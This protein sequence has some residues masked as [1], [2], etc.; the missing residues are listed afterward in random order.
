MAKLLNTTFLITQSVPSTPSSGYGTLYASGSS[1]YFKNSSGINYNLLLIGS[2]SIS[3]YLTSA[4]WT[5]PTNIKYIKVVCAG[6]GSGGGSGRLGAAVSNRFG[7]GGGAGGG[8]NI[9][10]FDSSSLTTN[11]YTVTVGGGGAG[12]PAQITTA[13]SGIT[14]SLGSN[15]SFSSGSTLLVVGVGGN[16]YPLR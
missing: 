7:G 12:G 8:V 4:T 1:L 5:K 3:T 9:V 2:S 11:T 10:Y 6:G 16:T 13:A 14:G 15:S